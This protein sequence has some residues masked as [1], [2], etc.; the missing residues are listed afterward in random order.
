[1]VRLSIVPLHRKHRILFVTTG[2]SDDDEETKQQKR[3]RYFWQYNVQAKG[4]KGQRL[5]MKAKLEDPHV[6]GEVQDPVFSPDCSLRGI[7]H[8]GKARKGDGNDLTPNPRKLFNIGKE[9]DNL[10]KVYY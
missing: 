2:D 8:S 5:V 7:K 4:P 10:A 3:D 1:M 9:L 6:L